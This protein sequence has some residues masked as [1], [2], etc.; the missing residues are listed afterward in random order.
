MGVRYDYF[1]TTDRGTAIDWAVGPDRRGHP[2]SRLDEAG[3]DWF[4]MKSLDPVVVLGQ[5]VAY[6]R[7]AGFEAGDDGPEPV[8]PDPARWHAEPGPLI[9]EIPEDW[10][11]TLAAVG[12]EALP[13]IAARWEGIEEVRFGDRQEAEECARLFVGLARRARAAGHTLYCVACL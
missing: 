6:A 10:R 7:G 3:A 1:H 9:E 2:W 5:L 4:E 12:D 13:G 11:D 8:W